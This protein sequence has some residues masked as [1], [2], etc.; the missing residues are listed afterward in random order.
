MGTMTSEARYLISAV[1]GVLYNSSYEGITALDYAQLFEMARRNGVATTVADVM[2]ARP[3]VP[4]EVKKLFIKQRMVNLAQQIGREDALKTLYSELD[5]EQLR[6]IFLKG[7]LLN[8][9]YPLPFIRSMSDVDVYA[10]LE[11]LDRVQQLMLR[12]GYVPG[13][14]GKC[15]HY[16][17]MLGK[18]VKVEYHPELVALN[19]QYGECVFRK[20]HPEAASVAGHMDVWAHSIPIDEHECARQLLPEY[21]YVY[22]I[23]HMM[24]HFLTAGTGIRSVMDV[25]V[26]NHHY[27]KEWDRE[28]VNDLLEKFGLTTF[29]KHALALAD[30]WFDLGGLTYLPDDI[31]EEMLDSFEAYI[32]DSGT[33]GSIRHTLTR[34]ARNKGRVVGIFRYLVKRSFPPYKE[35]C[36]AFPVLE[37]APIL[38]PIAWVFRL[39]E[40]LVL[41]CGRVKQILS[42]SASVDMNQAKKQAELFDA[43]IG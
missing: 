24:N 25:W 20:L 19:S 5:R 18:M 36:E 21:H 41:R 9:L 4:E 38:L 28:R 33:Y 23:I 2:C 12:L 43:M 31:D 16:E 10:E 35:M 34:E 14:I 39:G 17:Y 6:G 11:D 37:K 3:E 26:M 42:T 29:E 8:E 30:R 1:K 32:L 7:T 40:Y 27:G 13:I 22:V 15:N